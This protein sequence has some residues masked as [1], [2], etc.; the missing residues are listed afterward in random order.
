MKTDAQR[1]ASYLAKTVPATMSLKVAAVLSQMKS[2]YT[3]AANSLT[4]K[5][6]AIQ[7]ILNDEDVPTIQYPFYL[8]FGRELWGLTTR[9]IDGDSLAGMAQSLHDKYE[10]YGLATA[11]LVK[12]ALDAFGIVVT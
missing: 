5:E 11:K 9:G 6:I 10:G 7:S 2:G 1:I 4:G 3:A 12:I 8:N